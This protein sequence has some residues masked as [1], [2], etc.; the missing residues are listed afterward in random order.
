[1]KKKMTRNEKVLTATLILVLLLVIHYA[2]EPDVIEV[3]VIAIVEVP[4]YP[5][6][7]DLPHG[8][9]GVYFGDGLFLAK[10]ERSGLHELGHAINEWRGYP[11]GS[12]FFKRAVNTYIYYNQKSFYKCHREVVCRL[13]YFPGIFGNPMAEIEHED[14][15]IGYWGGYSEAYAEIYAQWKT[16]APLPEIFY[17]F[18]GVRQ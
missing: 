6:A 8:V 1:M 13:Q 5:S 2:Q 7:F 12:V 9:G 16:W 4:V 14:G 15:S 11:S 18:Y 17:P 3:P 10:N